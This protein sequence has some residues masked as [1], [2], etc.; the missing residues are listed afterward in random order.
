MKSRSLQA[1][2]SWEA[3]KRAE[4]GRAVP[5]ICR[6]MGI[7]RRRSILAREVRCKRPVNPS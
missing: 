1:P 2:R 7:R 6:E 5:E 4:S 3:L